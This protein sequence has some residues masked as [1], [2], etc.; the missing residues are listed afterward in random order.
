[1]SSSDRSGKGP[2]KPAGELPTFE[3]VLEDALDEAELE[4]MEK[5]ISDETSF[6]ESECADSSQDLDGELD[7]EYNGPSF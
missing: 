5:M 7:N 2:C 6:S 3:E 4:V 1:M